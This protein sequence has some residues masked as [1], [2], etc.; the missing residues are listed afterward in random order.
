MT[1]EDDMMT[2]ECRMRGEVTEDGHV[3]TVLEVLEGFVGGPEVLGI[4]EGQGRGVGH[5]PDPAQDRGR[6]ASQDP[7][8]EREE[9]LYILSMSLYCE[10]LCYKC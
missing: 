8:Q 7:D 3:H 6:G 2:E 9:V 10:S 5:G 4:G 1:E